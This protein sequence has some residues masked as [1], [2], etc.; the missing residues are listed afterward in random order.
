MG[1][2][3]DIMYSYHKENCEDRFEFMYELQNRIE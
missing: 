3:R 1:K 2:R